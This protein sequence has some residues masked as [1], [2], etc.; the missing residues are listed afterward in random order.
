MGY[1]GQYI[2]QQVAV[3]AVG[4]PIHLSWAFSDALPLRP[5]H[6]DKAHD[7]ELVLKHIEEQTG[8]TCSKENRKVRRLIV[9]R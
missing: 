7:A 3:D 6:P 8:L 1:I 5:P 2:N 9:A 4:V